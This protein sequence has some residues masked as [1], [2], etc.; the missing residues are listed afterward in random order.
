[1]SQSRRQGATGRS[2]DVAADRM[3]GHVIA[4]ALKLKDI[5]TDTDEHAKILAELIRATRLLNEAPRGSAL[6]RKQ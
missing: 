1:M 2:G 6:R 4:L 3:L 5:E